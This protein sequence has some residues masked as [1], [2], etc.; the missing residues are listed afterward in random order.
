LAGFLPLTFSIKFWEFRG[1]IRKGRVGKKGLPWGRKEGT[2]PK[3]PVVGPWVGVAQF[4]QKLF[5]FNREE[6]RGFGGIKEVPGEVVGWR[7]G[8]AN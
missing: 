3:V 6:I 8:R 2:W 7:I 5:N 1:F 4:G